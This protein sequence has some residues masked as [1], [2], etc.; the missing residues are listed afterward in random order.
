M[1]IF[2][3]GATGYIGN[4]VVEHAVRAGH[5]VEGLARNQGGAAKVLRLGA[6]PVLGDLRSFDVLRAAASRADAVLHLAYI[7][8]FSLDYSI[9]VDTEV[10]AVTALAKG[11]KDTLGTPSSPDFNIAKDATFP[12]HRLWHPSSAAREGKRMVFTTDFSY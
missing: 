5:A 4:V 6:A 10:K 9:V 1:K 12:A 3:T 8:D 11:A 2:A 7:H